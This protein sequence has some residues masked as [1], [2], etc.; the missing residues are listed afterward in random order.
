MPLNNIQ[1]LGYIIYGE[2]EWQIHLPIFERATVVLFSSV[3]ISRIAPIL[4]QFRFTE[5]ITVIDGNRIST[6][7]FIKKGKLLVPEDVDVAIIKSNGEHSEC[8]QWSCNP[9]RKG[10]YYK[11]KDAIEKVFDV[12]LVELYNRI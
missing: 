11:L 1:S 10:E 8:I 6:R 5:G 3:F 12:V 7:E 9:F 4:Q 2:R